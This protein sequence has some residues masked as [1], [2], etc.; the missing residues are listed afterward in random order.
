MFLLSVFNTVNLP[1][2]SLLKYAVS[3]SSN[4][5]KTLIS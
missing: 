2:K 4:A 3:E 1:L 5:H